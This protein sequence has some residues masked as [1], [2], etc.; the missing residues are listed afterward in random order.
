MKSHNQMMRK[1]VAEIPNFGEGHDRIIICGCVGPDF[2]RVG[3]PV[4][5]IEGRLNALYGQALLQHDICNQV[6]VLLV[7]AIPIVDGI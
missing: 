2:H 3:L 6:N 4:I 7:N 1:L 5:M